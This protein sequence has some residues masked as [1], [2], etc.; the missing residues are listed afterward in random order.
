[1]AELVPAIH[2]LAA[3]GPEDVDARDTS[4]FTRV[5]DALCPRMT[6]EILER[7]PL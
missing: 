2:V 6:V 3:A 4:A 7:D 1:M 5:F